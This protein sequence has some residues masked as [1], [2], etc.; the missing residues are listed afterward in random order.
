M[1]IDANHSYLQFTPE[2]ILDKITDLEIF[3]RYCTHFKELNIPFK[4]DLRDD[5]SPSCKIG[6][7]R[8][9]RRLIYRDFSTGESYDCFGYLQQK[10]AG[11]TLFEVLKVIDT[12]FNLNLSRIRVRKSDME[13]LLEHKSANKP[14]GLIAAKA[15]KRKIFKI[16]SRIWTTD[17]DKYWMRFSI[18][19]HDLER[20]N[21]VPVYSYT[22]D[23][24][25]KLCINGH[26]AYKIQNNWKIYAPHAD[27]ENKWRSNTHQY[28][29]Q[30]YEQLPSEGELLIITSSLKDVIVLS[31][32]GYPAIAFVS[33][34]NMPNQ[35]L[36]INL[37]RRFIKV[38][39]L[40][41]N[42]FSKP[43][44]PG[45]KAAL[46]MQEIFA[47]AGYFAP[48]I[49]LPSYYEC[50]DPAEIVDKHDYLLLDSLIKSELEN[51]NSEAP[52]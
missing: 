28:N 15:R 25:P 2:N 5:R 21:V 35:Q 1:G 30:G 22:A 4:S 29:I 19:R 45:Q 24:I 6:F 44:N 31:K 3:R 42:D 12:D 38:A 41:N 52:F 37:H 16:I 23:G 34:H 9:S 13:V 10:W 51:D 26:Y 36:C 48:N 50:T 11:H 46:K 27:K 32:L 43:D 14:K 8:G 17:D 18:T 39:I 33:E 20:F 49:I 7:P 47:M 40:L